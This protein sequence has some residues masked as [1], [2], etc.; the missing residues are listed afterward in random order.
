MKKNVSYC[1]QCLFV[2]LL[3]FCSCS[4]DDSAVFESPSTSVALAVSDGNQMADEYF[5]LGKIPDEYTQSMDEAEKEAWHKLSTTYYIKK[6]AFNTDYYKTHKKDVIDR[7]NYLYKDAVK[8]KLKPSYLSFVWADKEEASKTFRLAALNDSTST[9]YPPVDLDSGYVE[10]E[11]KVYNGKASCRVYNNSYA[12]VTM[13]VCLYYKVT[14][15][16]N[17]V[18]VEQ[19]GECSH[20]VYPFNA[21]FIG[22]IYMDIEE[23]HIARCAV[24]GYIYVNSRKYSVNA[25]SSIDLYEDWKNNKPLF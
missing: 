17:S 15:N 22:I 12:G 11:E 16:G 10:V 20:E 21:N 23:G 24:S 25:S 19:N 5:G 18:T 4:Q 6:N 7:I 2:G 13:Y 8:K 3:L 14:E 1:I 9:E